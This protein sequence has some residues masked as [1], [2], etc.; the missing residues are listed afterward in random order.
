M[1]GSVFTVRAEPEL[2]EPNFYAADGPRYAAQ[3]S[4]WS[5]DFDAYAAGEINASQVTC[6]LC[7][8]SPCDCPAFG[9][10]E[11]FALIDARHGRTP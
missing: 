8:H 11:Y 2:P 5:P 10:P 6:V 9:T 3:A 4:L 7:L 1:C